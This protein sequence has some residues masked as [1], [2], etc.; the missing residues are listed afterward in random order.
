MHNPRACKW[1]KCNQG[2][3]G[4]RATFTTA[5]ATQEFCSG[6]CRLD[7]AAW[8][9]IRGAVLVDLVIE[10]KWKELRELR[11]L[12]KKEIAP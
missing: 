12:M 9:Q 4:K 3:D 1:H 10:G 5:R 6:K 7:R 8:R 2:G 11:E